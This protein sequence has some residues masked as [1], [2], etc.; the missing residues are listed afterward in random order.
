M[1]SSSVFIITFENVS[2]SVS[3]PGYWSSTG[4]AEIFNKLEK[5]LEPNPQNDI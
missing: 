2:L 1:A 3:T 4:G 5:I